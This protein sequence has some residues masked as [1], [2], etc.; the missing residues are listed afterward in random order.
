MR[1]QQITYNQ[2]FF[3]IGNR[4]ITPEQVSTPERILGRVFYLL[5]DG[6]SP[7]V[8]CDFISLL[9]KKDVCRVDWCG[10]VRI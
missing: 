7:D 1:N 2:G 9:D 8:V 10:S 6:V 4:K 3:C 5:N